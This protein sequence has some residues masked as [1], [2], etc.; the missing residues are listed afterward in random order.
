MDGTLVD[1]TPIIHRAW[2]WWTSL[3]GIPLEPVL[4]VERGRPNREVIAQ[5]APWL[6][7]D[8]ESRRFVAYEEADTEGLTVVP[9]AAEAVRAGSSGLW[10][11]VT[12]AKCSLAEVR[13]RAAGLRLPEVLISSEM[14]TKGKPEPDGFLLAASRLGVEPRECVVFEDSAAGIAAA[15][16][17]R[18]TA[19]CIGPLE[20]ARAMADFH[21]QDFREVAISRNGDGQFRLALTVSQSQRIPDSPAPD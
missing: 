7:A 18:M 19:V 15:K 3:H 6:D 17:A 2:K 4:A 12:S 13:L 10:G 9:G 11:V 8:F 14:I 20:A 1:S 21:V 16:R 5:F